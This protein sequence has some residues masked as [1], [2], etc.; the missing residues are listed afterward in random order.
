MRIRGIPN[1]KSVKAAGNL[2]GNLYHSL[3]IGVI[4]FFVNVFKLDIFNL[5]IFAG[6]DEV[7][8]DFLL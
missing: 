3:L 6:F 7:F 5:V 4:G 1:L 8:G 2:L